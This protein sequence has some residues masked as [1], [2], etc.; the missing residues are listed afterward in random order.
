MRSVWINFHWYFFLLLTAGNL[1]AQPGSFPDQKKPAVSDTLLVSLLTYSP[2][3]ELY[4]LFGHSAL[5]IR[6]THTGDDEVYNYGTFDFEQPHFYPRFIQGNLLYCISSSEYKREMRYAK[7][8][9]TR[10][11]E[12]P[13]TL[14]DIEKRNLLNFLNTNLLPENR[15]YR[16][17]F[18]YD[19]CAT[20]LLD[21]LERVIPSGLSVPA[22]ALPIQTFRQL[23]HHYTRQR[24]WSE[25][26]IDLLM[27]LPSDRMAQAT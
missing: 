17:D 14:D 13:L 2:G 4:T 12:T 18:L 1:G 16:Y 25:L 22:E 11:I 19:N 6:N 24:P 27:G 20:R 8:H 3:S 5:R 9:F 7:R 23:L 15:N 21:V 10:V 26:G